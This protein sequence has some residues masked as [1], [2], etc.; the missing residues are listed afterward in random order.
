MIIGGAI[1]I[2][3]SIIAF[4]A[5]ASLGALAA[6]YGETGSIAILYIAAAIGVIGA[7]IQLVAGIMGVKHHNKAKAQTLMMWGIIVAGISVL[8]TILTVAGG[9][10]FSILSLLLGLV[11]PVL[12][13]VGA[14][15]N[16]N[17]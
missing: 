15:Q 14:I 13:I 1:G 16:K 3:V 17:A 10:S 11:L 9:G 12:F 4:V 7:V 2:I 6:Y 8:G 5:V